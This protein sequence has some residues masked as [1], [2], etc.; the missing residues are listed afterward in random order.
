MFNSKTQEPTSII[1]NEYNHDAE[2]GKWQILK[3][4]LMIIESSSQ[5]HGF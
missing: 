5:Y 1:L 2:N 3:N 4:M